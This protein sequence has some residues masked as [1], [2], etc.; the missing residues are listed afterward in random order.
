[1]RS[2]P[3]AVGSALAFMLRKEGVADLA[4]DELQSKALEAHQSE[5]HLRAAVCYAELAHRYD[6]GSAARGRYYQAFLRSLDN[7]EAALVS[8]KGW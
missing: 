3:P 8:P 2:V 4:T 5:E 6:K 1:M 7:V